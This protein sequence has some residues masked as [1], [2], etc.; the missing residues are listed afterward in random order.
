MNISQICI[1]FNSNRSVNS[2]TC[3]PWNYHGILYKY[4]V[5]SD[6]LDWFDCLIN[7]AKILFIFIYRFVQFM[8]V[9]FDSF[10]QTNLNW[11]DPFSKFLFPN[12]DYHSAKWL[13]ADFV[14]EFRCGICSYS[15]GYVG[16][17][18]FSLL[19]TV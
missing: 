10:S 8:C 16:W 9:C 7:T 19:W 4:M 18:C 17:G 5:P 3:K 14:T 2:S 15:S 13:I 11:I 12:F 6:W 1:F